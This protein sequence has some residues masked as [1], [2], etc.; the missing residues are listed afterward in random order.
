MADQ[1]PQNFGS[2]A[3]DG[4]VAAARDINGPVSIYNYTTQNPRIPPVLSLLPLM[5]GRETQEEQ[6]QDY[7]DGC[8]HKGQQIIAVVLPGPHRESPAHFV[9][10]YAKLS[11]RDA[12]QRHWRSRN[13]EYVWHPV[14]KWPEK[15][16]PLQ[17]RL[18]FLLR[19]LCR[20]IDGVSFGEEGHVRDRLVSQFADQSKHQILYYF[21]TADRVSGHDANLIG[22][23]IGFWQKLK[24]DTAKNMTVSIIFCLH[25][26]P[27]ILPIR[28][29][30][31]SRCVKALRTLCPNA[32][33]VLML[34]KLVPPI[35]E[36]DSY[37]WAFMHCQRAWNI[38]SKEHESTFPL[39][40][41]IL[42]QRAKNAFG[43]FRKRR[44]LLNLMTKL[45]EAVAKAAKP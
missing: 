13:Y 2:H 25:S 39:S 41:A 15:H 10:R 43:W 3:A 4:S 35:K 17:Q 30:W 14:L 42:Y 8:F 23:W 37:N 20:N 36:Q 19:D 24:L 33:D 18:D 32:P 38:A 12:Y 11:L 29:E 7:L 9:E 5:F 22:E 45:E 28:A 44:P 16:S 40:T 27:S 21:L 26:E 6:L 31:S 1:M 34:E